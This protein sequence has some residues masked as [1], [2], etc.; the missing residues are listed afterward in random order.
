MARND[1]QFNLRVPVELKQKV[2][3]AAKESGRSINAE[4][5]YRLEKSFEKIDQDGATIIMSQHDS[6]MFEKMLEGLVQ[7]QQKQNE[8]VESIEQLKLLYPEDK[9]R[10]D[11]LE[12]SLKGIDNGQDMLH[13]KKSDES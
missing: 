3:E 9:E 7:V 2:E 13:Q 5:V 11:M 12:Q 10:L 4:A 1:P 8:M 6:N